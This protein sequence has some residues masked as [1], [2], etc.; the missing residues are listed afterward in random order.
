MAALVATLLLAVPSFAAEPAPDLTLTGVL[1][2]RDHRTWREVPFRVPPGVTR[3]TVAFDHT[4]R[5]EKSV[6][7]IGIRDPQRFRGWSGG[8]KSGFTISES[9]ATPSYLPGPIPA[10]TWALLLGVP[11][12][13]KSTEARWTARIHFDRGPE[14][15]GFYDKPLKTGLAWYRGD[16]HMHTAHSDGACASRRGVRVPCPVFKTVEAA[17]ARG[18]DFIAITDHNTTS[19]FEAMRELAPY[20]DDLLLIPGREIT[21]F[22]GH[23]NI[24]G[25]QAFLEF[26]L[27]GPKAPDMGAIEDEVERAGGL[28]SINHPGLPSGETCMGCGWTAKTD[29]A[30]IQAIEVENGGA[31]RSSGGTDLLSG[32]AFWEARLNARFRI[33]GIG[34]SD[35]HDATLPAGAPSAVGYPT[36]V[37]HAQALSQDAILAAIRSGHVFIDV[38]G[39]KDRLLEA[40]TEARGRG[41]EMGDRVPAA[42]GVRLAIRLHVSH[43]AGGHIVVSGPAASR[44]SLPLPALA[45]DD[46][47]RTVEL[48]ADGADEWLRFD[49]RGADGKAW[50]IGNPF[51]LAGP[52]PR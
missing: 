52:V 19:H 45:S 17:E 47:T 27:G 51:Y 43:A 36:T 28:I 24:F 3:L 14:F 42:P 41:F 21:T 32:L 31:L 16:L 26:R 7:D 8:D 5:E 22:F 48:A 1:T 15:H 30:R 44:V 4:G 38:Q 33:T 50:L 20:F 23:A 13:R 9:E 49:V 25:P 11:N 29:D 6:I 12:L 10:G 35:N 18:L 34:G 37:V 2:G 46:E 39:T 40:T